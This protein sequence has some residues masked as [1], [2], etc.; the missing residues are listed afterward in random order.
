MYSKDQDAI[1]P[2][3]LASYQGQTGSV[4]YLGVEGANT[5][6]TRAHNKG[7][8]THSDIFPQSKSLFQRLS[9]L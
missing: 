8:G 6:E 9:T 4:P 3:G 2:H 1:T 5:G 7:V